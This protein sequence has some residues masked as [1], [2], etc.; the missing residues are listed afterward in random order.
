MPVAYLSSGNSIHFKRKDS[1]LKMSTR[2]E[3]N[4]SPSKHGHHYGSLRF[5]ILCALLLSPANLVVGAE[6]GKNN[7]NNKNNKNQKPN[8]N[9]NK[10]KATAPPTMAPT[11]KRKNNNKKEKT[12][13]P[14]TIALS[15]YPTVTPTS[16]CRGHLSTAASISNGNYSKKAFVDFIELECPRVIHERDSNE[17]F[18]FEYD[19]TNLPVPLKQNYWR[20]KCAL[21]DSECN[22]HAPVA[23]ADLVYAYD[24]TN[25][26]ELVLDWLC[27][28]VQS[29]CIHHSTEP[30]AMPSPA[31]TKL[32]TPSPTKQPTTSPSPKPTDQPTTSPSPKPSNAP[33]WVAWTKPMIEINISFYIAET[34]GLISTED[35]TAE[36]RSSSAFLQSKNIKGFGKPLT[37]EEILSNN[38]KFLAMDVLGALA[39]ILCKNTDYD[40]LSTEALTYFDFCDGDRE[41][42]IS[43]GL[44]DNAALITG[45]KDSWEHL[46]QITDRRFLS[47]GPDDVEEYLYWTVWTIR[48]PV[49]INSLENPSS[50]ESSSEADAILEIQ[51]AVDRVIISASS[52]GE[53]DN[54]LTDDE[55]YIF[56]ASSVGS[57]VDTF[58]KFGTVPGDSNDEEDAGDT[59]DTENSVIA[60]G[61]GVEEE[62]KPTKTFWQPL[63]IVGFLFLILGVGIFSWFVKVG[64]RKAKDE[65]FRIDSENG[66]RMDR[67]MDLTTNEGLDIML[68]TSRM[69]SDNDMPMVRSIRDMV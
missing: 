46:V 47:F 61:L 49:L 69:N 56:A 10:N 3:R 51:K 53:I 38:D 64:G 40:I 9:K 13:T 16:Q 59:E 63:R 4:N 48:Y 26:E 14:P 39:N 50:F 41:V 45:S 35:E 62:K 21:Q 24:K 7:K 30:T 18:D 17:G 12:T 19:F 1:K 37:A 42:S 55:D 22:K 32:P 29:Y 66:D 68:A 52:R 15:E 43:D 34:T 5:V 57:E 11:V 20:T 8:Q 54:L 44:G 36:A 2:R 58:S 6:E 33:S 25:G 28:Q 23:F 27:D 67:G 60:S 31:P 65:A